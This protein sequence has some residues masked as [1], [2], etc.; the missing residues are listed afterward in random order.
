MKRT[1]MLEAGLMLSV[2][3]C[4]VKI[5]VITAAAEEQKH[6]DPSKS[7][8]SKDCHPNIVKHKYKHG[9]IPRKS[10]QI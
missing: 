5:A 4:A 3:W 7:C 10:T 1:P 2:L 9:P 6:S 8:V